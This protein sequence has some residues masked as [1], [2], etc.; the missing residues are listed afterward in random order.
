MFCDEI[1]PHSQ[2]NV[3]SCE[4][5]ITICCRN[6]KAQTSVCTFDDVK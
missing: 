5:V 1:Q 6:E 3:N 4:P 2:Y